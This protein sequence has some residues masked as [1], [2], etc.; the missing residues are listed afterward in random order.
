MRINSGMEDGMQETWTTSSRSPRS[1]ADDLVRRRGPRGAA[2]V[3]DAHPGGG[4]LRA[5]VE[6]RD[7]D[8]F[9]AMLAVGVVATRGSAD[10]ERVRGPELSCRPAVPISSSV[11]KDQPSGR[12]AFTAGPGLPAGFPFSLA[13]EANGTL[14]IS[15]MPALNR[16]IRARHL[17]LEEPTRAWANIAAIAAAV[18]YSTA[19]F[20]YV[21]VLLGDIGNYGDINAWWR[22]RVPRPGRGV[23]RLTFRVGARCPLRREDR[24]AG[25]RRPG[26]SQRVGLAPLATESCSRKMTGD[27]AD[28][29]VW[30]AFIDAMRW[31][32]PG[33]AARYGDKAK[34]RPGYEEIAH[35][36]DWAWADLRRP[37][38]VGDVRAV[39]ARRSAEFHATLAAGA[40]FELL[41]SGPRTTWP[42]CGRCSPGPWPP[43]SPA[44]WPKP[45]S[46]FDDR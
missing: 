3:V 25:G 7:G 32:P 6:A 42:G 13:S 22:R 46:A 18:G 33:R 20:L 8:A 14:Y 36:G 43:I 4:R 12:A 17:R 30:D 16:E 38:R 23:A 44:G 11:T 21:Q 15:G 10:Q 26:R 40:E 39:F 35:R 9:G 28:D 24:T 34:P 29:P 1:R 45:D 37:A 41:A 19:D 27:A 5:A 31:A 2:V